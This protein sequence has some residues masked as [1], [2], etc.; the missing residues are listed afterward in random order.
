MGS[1][2]A[3]QRGGLWKKRERET[4]TDTEMDRE[5]NDVILISDGPSFKPKEAMKSRQ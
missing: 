4:E 1:P 5:R 2:G 3:E